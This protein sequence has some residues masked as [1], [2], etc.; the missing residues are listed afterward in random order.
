[1][2]RGL[3]PAVAWLSL[4]E[5]DSDPTRFLIYLVAALRTLAANIGEGVLSVLRPLCRRQ[6]NQF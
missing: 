2:G 4:D 5:G 3:R 1:M 6:R